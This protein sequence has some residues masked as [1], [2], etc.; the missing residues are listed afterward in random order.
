M[1]TEVCTVYL[2]DR[3]DRL[4]FRATEGLNKAVLGTL[5]LDLVKAS[6]SVALREEPINTELKL[7]HTFNIFLKLAKM[8]FFF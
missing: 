2:V 1:G 7:I 5:S 6:R 3:N 4:V 8:L